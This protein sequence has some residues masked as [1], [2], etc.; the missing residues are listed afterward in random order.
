MAY[1]ANQRTG[2]QLI[3]DSLSSDWLNV[4]SYLPQ[5]IEDIVDKLAKIYE[6]VDISELSVDFCEFI[7]ELVEEGF[8]LVGDT[9]DEITTSINENLELQLD[10][11]PISDLTVEVT[12]RCNER[13]IHCYL[14]NKLK[15]KGTAMNLEKL[16]LLIDSFAEMEGRTVTLTGGEV[17][18]YKE[19]KD[20]LYYIHQRHLRIIIYSN[21]IVLNDEML[22]ILESVNIDHIQ[23]SLYGVHP[24]IHDTITGVK[25]S[26]ERTLRSIKMLLKT[27]IPLKIAC[28]VMRENRSDVIPVLEFA[29]KNMIP[30][31]LE[32]NITARENKDKDNL[33]H[34]LSLK[35]MESLL[36][37]LVAYDKEYTINLLHRHKNLYDEQFPFAE[38][39]NYPVCTAG[40]Y[41][42]YIT[43]DGKVTT[44]P[45]LQGVEM[46]HIDC[47]SLKE[48][49]DNSNI[50]NSLRKTT[51][52]S[53]RKC[54]S[55]EASDFCFR[56][57][58]R[59]YTECGD[60]MQI[61]QYACKMAFLAK[62]IIDEQKMNQNV[63]KTIKK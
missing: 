29:K 41:G 45:N 5:T 9:M 19:I 53:F 7:E 55:C 59:N 63:N 49:W 21:L 62:R 31:D 42:L 26:C 60:Y 52:C 38:Y 1:I 57:F 48:I 40:H 18:L 25:G 8:V 6:D 51:E 54:V 27:Q 30:V 28:P 22:R 61:P 24:E 33:E 39:L 4:L 20:L 46:G 10:V 44:C 15:D 17:F 50:I 56:C 37:D 58:A 43:S 36:R 47:S 14:P 11:P 16:K 13:C 3:Y 2:K 12:N 23:V 35:E 34:R 32:L